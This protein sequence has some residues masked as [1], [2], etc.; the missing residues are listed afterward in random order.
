MRERVKWNNSVE[1]IKPKTI[2]QWNGNLNAELRKWEESS[3]VYCK[4]N[5]KVS[6]Q[7]SPMVIQHK[8]REQQKKL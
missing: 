8:S 7:G 6:I 3:I 5:L 2:M 1:F 4:E